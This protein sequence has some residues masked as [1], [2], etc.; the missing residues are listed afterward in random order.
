MIHT[1]KNRLKKNFINSIG[2]KSNRKL[3]TFQSDDWG[4][5][6][7]PYHISNK[8][9]NDAGINVD[10]CHYLKFDSIAS[11][12]DVDSLFD[13]LS[14]HKDNHGN[15]PTFNANVILNN[16]N[17]KKI[18][19]HNYAE[20]FSVNLVETM[21][22]AGKLNSD[23]LSI[24]NKGINS[25]LFYPQLHGFHHLN[26]LRWLRYLQADIKVIRNA[27]NLGV[28]GVSKNSTNEI[29]KSV[30]AA[31]DYDHPKDISRL[32]SLL[33]TAHS[34]FYKYFNYNSKSF[35]AP[36]YV[37]FDEIENVLNN[38]NIK[39]LQSASV[40][41]V[42]DAR[43]KHK[44][45]RHFTGEMNSLNQKYIIRNVIFE[46]SENK[47]IDWVDKCL[48]E[49]E[50]AFLWKK[51]AVI[52]THRVNF[53]GTRDSTNRDEGLFALNTLLNRI[54]KKWPDVEFI[55]TDSLG[56]LISEKK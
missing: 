10:K 19:A 32:T 36:N 44:F 11:D 26:H 25:S 38:L 7:I 40:Q 41:R 53:V 31:F 39:Y 50:I 12:K 56:D 34:D 13:L 30:L 21:N 28:F 54:L 43:K 3:I 46:P 17:F 1:L 27:F 35:I 9:L 23:T 48:N 5:E 15:H 16:P 42:P 52:S 4:S 18:K 29:D 45:K 33:T 20:Y 6:R 14:S 49:I 24:W 2:W 37:W 51:P 55:N 47:N 22:R 8:N